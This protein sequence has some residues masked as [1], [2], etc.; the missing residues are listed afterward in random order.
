MDESTIKLNL[1]LKSLKLIGGSDSYP[2]VD[3]GDFQVAS[4]ISTYWKCKELS[5]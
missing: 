4:M 3:W 5:I 1:C 2:L